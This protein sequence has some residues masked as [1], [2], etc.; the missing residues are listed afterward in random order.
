MLAY[1]IKRIGLG[2]AILTAVM[3]VMYASVFIVPGNPARAALG[4]R[5]TQ[6]MVDKLTASMGLDQPYYVQVFRFFKGVLT[7]DFGIDV[8]SNRPVAQEIW[9]VL[10]NTLIL[11]GIGLGW[12]VLLAIPLGCLAVIKRDTWIDRAAGLISVSVISLP[13]YVIAVYSLLF[14]AVKL[15]WLPA[16]GDGEDGD[17]MSQIR[18]LILPAF[19]IGVTWV[20]YLARLVRASMLEVMGEPHIR[21][22]RAFGLPETKI[23]FKY[24]LRIA[25]IPTLSL[26]AISLGGLISNAVFVEMVFT[27]PGIGKLVTNAVNLRNYPVVMGAVLVMTAI[28]VSLT[29][30][31]DLIIARLD[32][33]IRDAFRGA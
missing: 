23:V 9:E 28:Y 14:F 30:T 24:A 13:Y 31:A 33:R 29:I 4:P 1:A 5:A 6:E 16:I 8:I 15:Q 27:R 32:P 17:I 7:G 12:A 25:I 20:G 26:V 22:A 10:P 11:C 2:L 3:L 18:A 21:T 19:A